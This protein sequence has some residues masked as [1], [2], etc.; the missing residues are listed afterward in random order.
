MMYDRLPIPVTC[1]SAW[2]SFLG[3]STTA[4][5][6]QQASRCVPNPA[7]ASA[8]TVVAIPATVLCCLMRRI[9]LTIIFLKKRTYKSDSVCYL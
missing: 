3:A 7:P 1:A 4:S 8:S 5:P 2:I 9:R 6:R